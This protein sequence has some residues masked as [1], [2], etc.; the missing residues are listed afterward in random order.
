MRARILR[1]AV[2]PLIAAIIL[3]EAAGYIVTPTEASLSLTPEHIFVKDGGGAAMLSGLDSGEGSRT[4]II[5]RQRQTD[6]RQNADPES[7]FG[8][9]RHTSLLTKIGL[10]VIFGGFA[11][12]FAPIGFDRIFPLRNDRRGQR[13]LSGMIFSLISLSSLAVLLGII[14]AP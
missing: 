1:A 3:L 12:G 6:D 2:Q 13:L 4:R 8:Y 7:I 9:I 11:V 14:F 10:V 5:D